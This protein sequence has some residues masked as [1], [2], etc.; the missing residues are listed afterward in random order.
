MLIS[1]CQRNNHRNQTV[2]RPQRKCRFA[3]VADI[4]AVEV[5]VAARARPEKMIPPKR[6]PLPKESHPLN[7]RQQ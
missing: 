4:V 1:K 3:V 2:L 7:H 5:G 6:H